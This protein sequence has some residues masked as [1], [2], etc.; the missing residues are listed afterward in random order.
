MAI[1]KNKFYHKSKFNNL[2]YNHIDYKLISLP[3]EG[4]E[5]KISVPGYWEYKGYINVYNK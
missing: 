2:K 1:L 4:Y 5:G 3:E